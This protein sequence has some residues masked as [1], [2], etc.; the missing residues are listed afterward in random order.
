MKI[1]QVKASVKQMCEELEC[2]DDYI[3]RACSVFTQ[4][5]VTSGCSQPSMLRRNNITGHVHR[6]SNMKCA[7]ETECVS[8]ICE[9]GL[10]ENKSTDNLSVFFELDCKNFQ[11]NK[12]FRRETDWKISDIGKHKT[13][14]EE[15]LRSRLLVLD[16]T[17]MCVNALQTAVLTAC[18]VL[19]IGQEMGNF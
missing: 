7:A 17:G 14:L 2:S 4:A 16:S 11:C 12:E 9:C 8:T 18:S 19:R 5:L 6:L 3:L 15:A 1:L 13:T 10:F